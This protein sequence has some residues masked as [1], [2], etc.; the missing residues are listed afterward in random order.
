MRIIVFSCTHLCSP[1]IQQYL[2][3][4]TYDYGNVTK[5]IKAIQASPPDMVVNLGD[6]E[7]RLYEPI[8]FY[9]SVLPQYDGI[10]CGVIKLCG[11]HDK[12]DGKDFVTIDGIR[13]EHGHIGTRARD[14]DSIRSRFK[15]C[16]IVH[17]HSHVPYDG[18]GF[19]VGSIT[20]SGTYG[21][22]IDGEAFLRYVN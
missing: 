10:P 11:N 20:F 5:M 8:G 9:K 4:E 14:V 18:W 2:H 12:K 7:E 16:K 1:D 17:G 15:N 13:Y 19:D 6:F 3:G 22:V 21:E